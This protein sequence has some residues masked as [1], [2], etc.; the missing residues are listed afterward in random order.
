M[1]EERANQSAERTEKDYIVHTTVCTTIQAEMLY[2][3]KI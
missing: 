2:N 1:K 3:V